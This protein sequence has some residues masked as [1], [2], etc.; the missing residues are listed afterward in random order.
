MK[1]YNIEKLT[2]Y[3]DTF[4]GTENKFTFNEF[5]KNMEEIE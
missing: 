4:I 1:N 2:N 3:I 5:V